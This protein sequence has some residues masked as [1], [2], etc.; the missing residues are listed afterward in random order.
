MKPNLNLRTVL[1]FIG[2]RVI[3]HVFA[4][5][6]LLLSCDFRSH[7]ELNTTYH[8]STT[9]RLY[10]PR[11]RS[12]TVNSLRCLGNNVRLTEISRAGSMAS[13]SALACWMFMGDLLSLSF[14]LWDSPSPTTPVG[15]LAVLRWL[16]DIETITVTFMSDTDVICIVN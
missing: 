2:L 15:L 8:I 7:R 9:T 3:V 13:Q 14:V 16:W 10:K 1:G 6:C 4:F 5:L 11:F 12:S